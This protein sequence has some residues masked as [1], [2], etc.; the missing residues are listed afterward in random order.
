MG[1][2]ELRV[3]AGYRT[4]KEFAES[5]GISPSTYA[6][7]E[8][9][10]KSIPLK[11][12][13]TIADELGCTIDAVVGRAPAEGGAASAK[14]VQRLY[15]TASVEGRR[16]IDDF[17]E[18]VAWSDRRA[19]EQRRDAE[20][21][22][23]RRYAARLM[24]GFYERAQADPSLND[25]VMF[26][27]A[28]QERAAFE[29]FVTEHA[30]SVREAVVDKDVRDFESAQ[31]LGMDESGEVVELTYDEEQER[32]LAT[33]MEEYREVVMARRLEHDEGVIARIMAAY[34]QIRRWQDINSDLMAP[35]PGYEF[36]V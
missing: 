25:V 16:R 19:A 9:N 3:A 12:A 15:E 20:E 13:W 1:L 2:Q 18:Y 7:Y 6:R 23:G 10:P 34:D 27:T 36:V 21:Y 32:L 31:R 35:G 11:S 17:M 28:E 8:Q 4:G 22:Q 24:E 14:R 30:A 33:K 5:A 26:G 29:R